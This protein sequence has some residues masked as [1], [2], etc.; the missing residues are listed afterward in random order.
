MLV[1]RAQRQIT[2][3]I[4]PSLGEAGCLGFGRYQDAQAP[5][6]FLALE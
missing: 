4:Q 3:L 1:L 2:D 5:T 6:A